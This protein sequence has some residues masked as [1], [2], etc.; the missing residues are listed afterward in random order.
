MKIVVV[1]SNIHNFFKCYDNEKRIYGELGYELVIADVHSPEEYVEVA[2]DADALMVIGTKTDA[3]I[4]EQLPKVK[5]ITTYGVGFDNHDVA[6]CTELGIVL[7]N[8]PN[9]GTNEVASHALAHLLN[10]AKKVSYYNNKIKQEGIWLAGDGY[11]VHRL[12]LMTLGLCGFGNIAQRVA[13]FA[14]NLFQEII[15]FDPFTPDSVFEEAGVRRVTFEELLAQSDAI[16]IHTPLNKDTYHQ[17]DA[18]AFAKCKPGVIVVSTAR[19]GVVD[20]DALCDAIDQGIVLCAGLDVI[21]GEPVTSPDARVMK[22]DNIYMSPH[23][24]AES[25]EYT[26]FLQTAAAETVVKVLNGEIPSNAINGKAIIEGGN[27][28]K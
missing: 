7:C 15:A 6:K 4:L 9:Y 13:H 2:K 27:Q 19:G 17:F 3:A 22:Y 5:V 28:R 18:A 12:P 24:A 10:C 14:K 16:S 1:D 8:Q 25:I 21:E 23:T 11:K 20:T 26:K